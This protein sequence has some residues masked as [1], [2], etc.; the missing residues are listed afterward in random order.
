MMKKQITSG[1]LNQAIEIYK[2]ENIDNPSG[3]TYPQDVL[4]WATSAKVDQIKAGRTLQALQDILAP[5]VEFTVRYRQDKFVTPDMRIK[6][7][8]QY[9]TVITAEVDYVAKEFLVIIGRSSE[10]PER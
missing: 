7:R 1:D 2:Q 10:L 8:G 6:W 4:Y 5:S 9:F 3:G